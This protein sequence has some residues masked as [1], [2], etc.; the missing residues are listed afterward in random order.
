VIA[1]AKNEI[2]FNG[3]RHRFY[4]FQFSG[5]TTTARHPIAAGIDPALNGDGV[6][7]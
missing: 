1:E 3:S 4:Y 7:P 2:V 5:Y 6:I